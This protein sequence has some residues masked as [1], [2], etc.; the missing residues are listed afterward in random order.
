MGL[1]DILIR[2][3]ENMQFTE[4]TP[5]Q[6]QAIPVALS[7]KDILG[8][9][10]TGTGKTAAFGIP[11]VAK[12]LSKPQSTAL[13][14][15]PTR[16]LATQV[17]TQLQTMLG[18]PS[19]I[20][21][22]LL[23][24]GDSM[25]KQLMQLRNKPRLIVGTPGRINDHL[26]RGSLLLEKAD[27]LVLDET[28]RMLDMGFSCQIE[29]IV[30]EMAEARQTLLFSATLPKNIIHIAKKYL[31]DPTQISV[32]STTVPA[33]HIQ[34]ETLWVSELDKY[35][36]LLSQ[37][38]A[39]EGTIIIFVKTK[40]GTEKIATKLVKAGYNAGAIHGDLRQSKR[41]RI[42]MDFRKMK[43]RI[44]VATDVAARGLD[45]PH[46]EH[47]IN[48]DLPQCA[49]DYIHRIG[50]TARAGAEGEALSF[51]TPA[52]KSKWHAIECLLNPELKQSAQL[53]AF[54]KNRKRP[55]RGNRKTATTPATYKRKNNKN[56]RM[57]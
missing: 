44:L 27:F 48:Y 26:D 21:T 40:H 50:R 46:I 17:M 53:P 20:K 15:T 54:S 43:Y 28:D 9:A 24:G 11:L 31:T 30:A 32:N 36:T 55:F 19:K 5:I 34:Q 49:E 12:L 45:V 3:L 8:S 2:N 35:P 47:V 39:R 41:D 38:D 42:M 56:T 52:D 33:E 7:G 29:T 10:Q 16:E 22:A 6:A 57:G 4:P 13:V 23:I 18:K 14:M 25:T 51:V 1:P 37:L